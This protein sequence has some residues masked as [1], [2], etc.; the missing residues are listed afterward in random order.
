MLAC[1]EVAV[2]VV[3]YNTVASLDEP[4]C[5]ETG[6]SEGSCIPSIELIIPHYPRA[7]IPDSCRVVGA[8]DW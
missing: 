1:C 2:L 4:L 5:S 7:L 6:A 3:D 8:L